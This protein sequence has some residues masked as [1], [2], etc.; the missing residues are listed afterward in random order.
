[1]SITKTLVAIIGTLLIG[2][3]TIFASGR[4]PELKNKRVELIKKKSSV[5]NKEDLFI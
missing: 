3:A 5:Q 1:M 4:K 2:V